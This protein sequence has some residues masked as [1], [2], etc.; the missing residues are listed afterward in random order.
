[1]TKMMKLADVDFKAAIMHI[2]KKLKEHIMKEMETIK[3]TK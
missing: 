1:M 2:I 3:K